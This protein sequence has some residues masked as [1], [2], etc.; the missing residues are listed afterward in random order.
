V[1]SEI[2]KGAKVPATHKARNDGSKPYREVLVE[3]KEQRA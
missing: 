2:G 3:Y 1:L